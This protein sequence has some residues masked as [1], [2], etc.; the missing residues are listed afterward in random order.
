V[1]LQIK[2]TRLSAKGVFDLE[3]IEVFCAKGTGEG[4]GKRLADV[5]AHGSCR[6][7]QP[8]SSIPSS[9]RPTALARLC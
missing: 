7:N 3:N 5:E 1:A 9:A 6:K 8:R 2:R 4:K